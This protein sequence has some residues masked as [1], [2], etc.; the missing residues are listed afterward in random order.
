M[1]G[2]WVKANTWR[3]VRWR[4]SRVK[5]YEDTVSLHFQKLP[6]LGGT[7][8]HTIIKCCCC[9]WE[10]SKELHKGKQTCLAIP[11]FTTAT[12]ATPIIPIVAAT[13]YHP[14][15]FLQ[16]QYMHVITQTGKQKCTLSS[17]ITHI[18]QDSEGENPPL[19]QLPPG[20]PIHKQE[21][22]KARHTNKLS[23][24]Y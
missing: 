5:L 6:R 8:H 21:I 7:T 2:E 13:T 22:I 11:I 19:G 17:Y 15:L 16:R 3:D 1:A 20:Y 9:V 24:I 4:G 18:Q 14:S 23:T 12:I 10:L